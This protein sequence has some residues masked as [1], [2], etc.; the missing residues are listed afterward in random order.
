MIKEIGLAEG[1][2]P[3]I[4]DI[5]SCLFMRAI[6]GEMTPR[7]SCLTGGEETAQGELPKE[8]ECVAPRLTCLMEMFKEEGMGLLSAFPF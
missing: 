4:E 1:E 3:P 2:I 7:I 5:I 8:A 6:G